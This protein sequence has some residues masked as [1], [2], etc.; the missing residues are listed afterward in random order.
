MILLLLIVFIL[1]LVYDIR[2]ILLDSRGSPQQE[3]PHIRLYD[4]SFHILG[5]IKFSLSG[6]MSLIRCEFKDVQGWSRLELN[7]EKSRFEP[8]ITTEIL[9]KFNSNKSQNRIEIIQTTIDIESLE[10][11]ID[12]NVLRHLTMENVHLNL[13]YMFYIEIG[14]DNVDK[15][16]SVLDLEVT[17]SWIAG[18]VVRRLISP[19]AFGKFKFVNT[20]FTEIHFQSYS[21]WRYKYQV[22]DELGPAS[23]SFDNCTITK[24]LCVDV[25]FID[26]KIL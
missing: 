24:S 25:W 14:S 13:S 15:P 9:K 18:R 1:L 2:W 12:N 6:S 5:R 3:L 21:K 4:C 17:N 11:Y 8:E 16:I 26:F 22:Y 7:L 23:F 19:N 10:L 20:V